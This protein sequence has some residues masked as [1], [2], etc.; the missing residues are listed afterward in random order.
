MVVAKVVVDYVNCLREFL[1]KLIGWWE[2]NYSNSHVLSNLFGE[3]SR[4]DRNKRNRGFF[5]GSEFLRKVCRE[6]AAN[7]K[8]GKYAITTQ[9]SKN[10]ISKKKVLSGELFDT[11]KKRFYLMKW[12]WLGMRIFEIFEKVEVLR[13]C[14]CFP[15]CFAF[16]NWGLTALQ[17]APINRADDSYNAGVL[18]TWF[19]NSNPTGTQIYGL[20]KHQHSIVSTEKPDR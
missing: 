7:F 16:P 8:R 6:F 11:I 18:R 4:N 9:Q 17:S 19:P 5:F 1:Y 2:N 12:R 3:M 13:G 10:I 14:I 20:K 15:R